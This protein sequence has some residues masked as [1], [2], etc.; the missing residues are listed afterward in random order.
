MNVGCDVH[1]H[2]GK[3]PILYKN[4]YPA[5]LICEYEIDAQKALQQPNIWVGEASFLKA[6]LLGDM[7]RFIPRPI[8]KIC[9]LIPDSC[10]GKSVTIDDKLIR[11]I[12]EI[13]WTNNTH[14]KIC[15]K[16][17]LIEF[18]KKHKGEECYYIC[19]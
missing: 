18:L 10:S 17:E 19:W 7:D 9:K 13:D 1:I 12:E 11:A 6:N 2:I 3:P 14:Y 4:P 5:S 16:K 15:D 8:Q